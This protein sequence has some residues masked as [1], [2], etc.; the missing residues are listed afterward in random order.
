[1]CDPMP[2]KY[3]QKL[4]A[5]DLFSGAGGLT[6]GLKQAGFRVLTGV[7]IN[8]LAART[9]RANHPDA[10]LVE[11]DIRTLSPHAVMESLNLERGSL[12]LLAGCPPCQGFSTLRTRRK[13][14]SVE[15]SR[16]DLVHEFM[17]WVDAIYPHVVMLENVPSLVKDS[18]METVLS[19]LQ[20]LGYQVTENSLRVEDIARYGIPQRRRRMILIVS[21]TGTINIEF[22][23]TARK[24]VREA[25]A[26]LKRAGESGDPLHDV[27]EQRTPRIQKMISLV[28]RDGGS[29][30]DLP[31]EYWLECHKRYPHGFRDVYGRMSWDDVSPT[32][33]GGCTN[34]SKGRF[35][36]PEEDRAITLR[37]AAILQTFPP[38]YFFPIGA[39]KD[40]ISLM[41]GNA[42]PPEFIRQQGEI[43]KKHLLTN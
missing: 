14:W 36:H 34:P 16:N 11:A 37:E 22:T 29:R 27:Q 17:Q 20:Q 5:I 8:S 9:Y 24:T 42:L 21:R 12:G 3:E 18:R 2:P 23:T 31:E 33:T 41:I 39:G 35:L 43:I 13:A 6:C 25:F 26:N 32:M 4:T 38:D 19:K 10:G 1:M 30:L 7:E 15:D 28:P 40:N